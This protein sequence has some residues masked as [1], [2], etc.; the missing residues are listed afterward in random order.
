MSHRLRD[1]WLASVEVSTHLRPWLTWLT[2]RHAELGGRTEIRLIRAAPDRGV[3]S[4]CVGPDHVERLIELLAPVGAPREHI[5]AGDHPRVG[6]GQVYFTLNPTSLQA[7]AELKKGRR[8][9]RDRDIVAPCLALID[10]DPERPSGV[11]ATAAERKAAEDVA[12]KVAGWLRERGVEPIRASSGNGY[13]L[14]VPLDGGPVEDAAT[15]TKALLQHLH[16]SFSTA[17]AKV[18]VTTYNPSRICKLYGT[19][20]VKGEATDERPH[21]RTTV[22]M[23][24]GLAFLSAER[25]AELVPEQP[26]QPSAPTRPGKEVWEA[27]RQEALAAVTLESVYGP[28]LTGK[29]SGQWLECRDP[30][31]EDR[32]PSAGVADG[33]GD[34]ERGVFHSFLDRKPI[35]LFDFLV[36]RGEAHDFMSACERVA[37]LSGVPLPGSDGVAMARAADP[38]MAL[39]EQSDTQQIRGAL[40]ALRETGAIERARGIE[41]IAEAT[42]LTKAVLRKELDALGRKATRRAAKAE[43]RRPEVRY[44]RNADRIEDLWSR[45]LEAVRPFDCLFERDGELVWVAPGRGTT[46][47]TAGNLPGLLSGVIEISFWHRAG[48]GQDECLGFDVLPADKARA[49]VSCLDVRSAIPKL[50]LYTRSPVIDVAWSFVGEPGYHPDSGVY[51]DG[52]RLLPAAGTDTLVRMLEDFR[53]SG[54]VDLVNT[55]GALLTA[56]TIVHWPVHPMLVIDG[57]ARGIGKSLLATVLGIVIEGQVPESISYTR[58]DEEFEKAIATCIDGGDRL[59]LIDNAKGMVDS[60]ALERSVTAPVLAFRRLGGN[61]KIRRT[62][63]V[64]FALTMNEPHLS[65]DLRRRALPVSLR[66]S[67]SVQQATYP[68]E[69]LASWVR[70]RRDQLVCELGGIVM[71]WVEAGRPR[72]EEPA[73]HSTSQLWAGSIDAMLRLS[74]FQG[75]LDNFEIVAQSYDPNFDIVCAVARAGWQLEAAGA[76]EWG[77]R[78]GSSALFDVCHDRKGQ[79]RTPRTRA[80][81]IGKLF[82]GY[83][84]QRIPVDDDIRVELFSEQPRGRTH[85]AVYGFRRVAP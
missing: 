36:L 71:R 14:L 54:P 73:R 81:L 2:R 26:A 49:M 33:S 37:V 72:C 22:A 80:V 53:F 63:D 74:G 83:V 57:N 48:D 20:A 24:E 27:W 39:C 7:S 13:H 52:R 43:S 50:T 62:N 12:A 75:F 77:E 9:T 85:S 44:V 11:S 10:V 78:L 60:A 76:M 68:I 16:A 79:R 17:G 64:L 61:T 19:R 32:N 5:P 28:W 34:F 51:Y 47:V 3:W 1:R 66:Y 56:L 84:G 4:G 31:V 15:R 6:E 25:F 67:G 23:P 35:S 82:S 42:G 38:A 65:P 55:V 8:A 45:I 58:G 41:R 21:R 69:D 59:V 40:A 29:A 46:V 70:E 18:D 30:R